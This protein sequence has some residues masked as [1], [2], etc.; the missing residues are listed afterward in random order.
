MTAKDSTID[1]NLSNSIDKDVKTMFLPITLLQSL[2]LCPKYYIKNNHIYPNDFINKCKTCILSFTLFALKI[3]RLY[4]IL[5]DEFFMKYTTTTI[6]YFALYLDESF[7]Y[8]I[9][10]VLYIITSLKSRQFVLFVL[11]FQKIYRLL[12]NGLKVSHII[13]SWFYCSLLVFYHLII[14]IIYSFALNVQW[15]VSVCL[16]AHICHD[17]NIIYAIVSIKLLTENVVQWNIQ[18]SQRDG[19][20]EINCQILLQTYVEILECFDT[21]KNCFQIPAL[22]LTIDL[23]LNSMINHEVAIDLCKR[24]Q[25]SEAVSQTK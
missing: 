19:F 16:F 18:V 13:N 3:Y 22:I 20:R 11:K 7:S 14:G 21:F 6:F 24:T 4:E 5:G 8:C 25:L 15:H 10:I 23:F 1:I 17:A 9:Y 12:K 2:V